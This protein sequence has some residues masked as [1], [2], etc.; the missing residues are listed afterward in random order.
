MKRSGIQL[1]RFRLCVRLA[2][3]PGV[4]AQL[5]ELLDVGVPGLEVDAAGALALAALIHRRHRGVE[6]LQPG[7]DAV[8]V[9]V[10]ALD[11]RAARAHAVVGE[12]DAARELREQGD[13]GVA[14]VDV[15]QVIVGRVEQEA[16]RE[17]LVPGARVEH[18]RRAGQVL[19][20]R[21]Q[22]VELERVGTVSESAQAMRRKNCC[23][24]STTS[25]VF[26]CF[27]R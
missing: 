18:R 6:R 17:L 24:V 26:G 16:A 11:E 13:V 21:E 19:E 8:G 27:S 1:A 20:P 25:R 5:E 3:S 2:S 15:L 4:V 10:R 12:A 23:G 22:A 7:D 9:P 14:L